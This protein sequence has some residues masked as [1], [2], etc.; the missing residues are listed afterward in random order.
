M[1]V[2]GHADVLQQVELGVDHSFSHKCTYRTLRDSECAP[3]I[4]SNKLSVYNNP[5]VSAVALPKAMP[6]VMSSGFYSRNG[7]WPDPKSS[8]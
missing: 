7:R 2:C 8:R 4:G 1:A 5:P 3:L 6:Y